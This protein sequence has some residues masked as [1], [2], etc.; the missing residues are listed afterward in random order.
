MDQFELL[1]R[2]TFIATRKPL[3]HAV[4]L[5]RERRLRCRTLAALPPAQHPRAATMA[6]LRGKPVLLPHQLA[7]PVALPSPDRGARLGGLREVSSKHVRRDRVRVVR[8]GS[9]AKSAFLAGDNAL[10]SHQPFDALPT[11]ASSLST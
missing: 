6:A 7:Q 10:L 3:H 9:L 4:A 1:K 11:D 2:R 8:V 5:R